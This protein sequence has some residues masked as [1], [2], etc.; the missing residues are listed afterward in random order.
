M[1][2]YLFKVAKSG[3]HTALVPKGMRLERKGKQIRFIKSSGKKGVWWNTNVWKLMS[4]SS[5]KDLRN[6]IV[7]KEIKEE[8]RYNKSIGL[9]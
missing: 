9:V 8:L 3:I 7:R 6:K 5:K 1:A 2:R 4:A